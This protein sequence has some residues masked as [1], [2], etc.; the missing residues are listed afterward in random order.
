[1]SV[2]IDRSYDMGYEEIK[3]MF[4]IFK[5]KETDM[6][7]KILAD[8]RM[9]PVNAELMVVNYNTPKCER[10]ICLALHIQFGKYFIGNSMWIPMNEN[11]Y[12]ATAAWKS[13]MILS[14]PYATYGKISTW[15]GSMTCE[16][17]F[18]LPTNII[19][20]YFKYSKVDKDEFLK[21]ALES[22]EFDGDDLVWDDRIKES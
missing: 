16:D 6:S 5:S 3:I 1:M 22:G 7:K 18:T 19:E 11:G 14:D 13:A 10:F 12:D 15:G 4:N 21:Q 20:N 2:V 9:R 17:A 8:V